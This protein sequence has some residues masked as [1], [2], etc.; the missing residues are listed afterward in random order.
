[1]HPRSAPPPSPSPSPDPAPPM[2]SPGWSVQCLVPGA[3][4]PQGVPAQPTTASAVEPFGS[5]WETEQSQPLTPPGIGNLPGLFETPFQALL[6]DWRR[7]SPFLAEEARKAGMTHGLIAEATWLVPVAM[8]EAEAPM[9]DLNA[10]LQPLGNP[11]M[12]LIL[13]DLPPDLMIQEGD[14][15]AVR[16]PRRVPLVG[17]GLGKPDMIVTVAGPTTLLRA[18]E[19][20]QIAWAAAHDRQAF[21]GDLA[22]EP[23]RVKRGPGR[24]GKRP[25]V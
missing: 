11:K 17:R 6:S 19:L 21:V 8:M 14:R 9:L 20:D 2:T 4:Q 15:L 3:A 7:R 24:P 25:T 10:G 13:V 23:A 22:P 1:M 12:T 18:S 5:W 16:D